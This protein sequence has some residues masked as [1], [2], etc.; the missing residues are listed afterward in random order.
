MNFEIFLDQ[1]YFIMSYICDLLADKLIHYI[2][3]FYCSKV[4]NTFLLPP[5]YCVMTAWFFAWSLRFH[6]VFSMSKWAA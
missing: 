6:H 2:V 4:K 5:H 3:L 1:K